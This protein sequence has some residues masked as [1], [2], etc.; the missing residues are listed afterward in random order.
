VERDVT[1]NKEA[2]E[3]LRK[4]EALFDTLTQYSPDCIKLFDTQGNLRFINK[5]G[6]K[7]HGYK[8]IEEALKRGMGVMLDS[9]T[10]DSKTAFKKAFSAAVRGETISIE[11]QH[12]KEGSNRKFCLE[13]ITP[14]RS[15][16]GEISG[17]MG[18][19]RD[20]SEHK[21]AEEALR[22]SEERLRLEV[23]SM[24][25]G[26]IVWDK[27]FRVVTWNPAAEKIFG[28]T[29]AEAKGQHPYDFIVPP[30]AQLQVD[31]IWR[32]LIVG[33]VSAN[34]VNENITKDGRIIT[35]E[36][37]NTP[38][39]QPDGAVLGA[40]SMIQDVTKEKEL[41]KIKNDFLTLASHQLR[42][43][44]SGTRWLIET[45]NKPF[46]GKLNK[47]QKEYLDELYKVNAK[48]LALVGDL[49]NL[50]RLESGDLAISIKKIAVSKFSD[51]VLAMM[52]NAAKNKGA[53]LKGIPEA[54]GKITVDTDFQI[55][56]NIL[57]S[58][59]SN[60]IEYSRT[61]EE[62]YLDAEENKDS[63]IL[64]VKDTGIGIPKD[65]QGRIFERFYRASNAKSIRP[66]GT[67]LGLSI[68]STLA[69]KIGAKLSFKSEEG[70]GST[71]YLNMPRK[72]S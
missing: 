31:D 68:A 48:M 24:P 27:D 66:G 43:P 64:S 70:E 2:E 16:D 36:W 14:I 33:D 17:I 39:K 1:E 6:L 23:S 3:A 19:S 11:V 29:F 52:E 49:L 35:C 69:Q 45:L 53:I 37:T 15:S 7:E 46:I 47:K 34:S 30:E 9:L 56:V 12:T 41:D 61:G 72:N 5:E 13:S 40:M 22:R 54:K 26:Y 18:I 21:K 32:R 65:E 4:Q 25:I 20:I 59:I 63:V 62:I 67:G 10:P 38:L 42:T 58:F 8:N 71:F 60:S 50:L 55:V 51:D 28:F 44:L 57:E